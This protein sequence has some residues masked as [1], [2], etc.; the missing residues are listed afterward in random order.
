MKLSPAKVLNRLINLLYPIEVS[1]K[2][3]DMKEDL[4]KNFPTSLKR[5]VRSSGI[6]AKLMIKAQF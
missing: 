3:S 4:Q 5:P 2:D 1:D 6:R